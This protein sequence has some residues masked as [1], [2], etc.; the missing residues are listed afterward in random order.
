MA[1]YS[2]RA[3]KAR[4]KIAKFG[5]M[6]TFHAANGEYDPVSGRMLEDVQEFACPALLTGPSE[7]MIASGSVELGDAILLVASQD[8]KTE[9]Q[10]DGL[11]SMKDRQW[12]IKG[13]SFVAPD[14]DPI[15]YKI[16]MRRA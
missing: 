11:V 7:K 16:T 10:I 1:D 5:S 8:M 13:Y 3:E 15:L 6:A 12:R 14:G 9:P 2:A 4:A